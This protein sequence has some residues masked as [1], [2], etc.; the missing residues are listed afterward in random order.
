MPIFFPQAYGMHI[1]RSAKAR[2]IFLFK[3]MFEKE[4]KMH[5]LYIPLGASLSSIISSN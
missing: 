3:I 4:S 5:E 1:E 2:W